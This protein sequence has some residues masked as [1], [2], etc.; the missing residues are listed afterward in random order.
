MQLSIHAGHGLHLILILLSLQRQQALE[1]LVFF[2]QCLDLERNIFVKLL[3][4]LL[5]LFYFCLLILGFLYMEALKA[6]N[7]FCDEFNL[8]GPCKF[9]EELH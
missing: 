6:Q 4:V 9:S 8:A 3:L 7:C 5:Q 2:C 1:L